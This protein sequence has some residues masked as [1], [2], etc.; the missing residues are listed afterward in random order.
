VGTLVTETIKTAE[1]FYGNGGFREVSD[2][3][4]LSY[5][6]FGKFVTPRG[7]L[8]AGSIVTSE[9]FETS[10]KSEGLTHGGLLLSNAGDQVFIFNGPM[11]EVELTRREACG[12]TQ[13]PYT[14]SYSQSYQQ[15]YCKKIIMGSMQTVR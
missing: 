4:W 15:S 11:K 10:M 3:S 6:G 7:G 12:T 8:A 9:M 1:E 2:D 14:Q 13:Q 5:E